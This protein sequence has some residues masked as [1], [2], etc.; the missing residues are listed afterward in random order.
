MPRKHLH[1]CAEF[2]A[3]QNL[4]VR[5]LLGL[6]FKPCWLAF[7]IDAAYTLVV[8]VCDCT[9][10]YMYILSYSIFSLETS[11]LMLSLHVYCTDLKTLLLTLVNF[12]YTV[13]FLSRC[14]IRPWPL[15]CTK[16]QVISLIFSFA[17]FFFF[18]Q[19]NWQYA[20]D[21]VLRSC[22]WNKQILLHWISYWLP[23][24]R[25][26]TGTR[27]LCNKCKICHSV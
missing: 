11:Y 26:W 25:R 24:V 10:L 4:T 14:H 23:C 17:L 15:T 20:R 2:F 3:L 5:N 16:K 9:W 8:I 1:V 13:Y 27:C 6:S 18:P 7:T 21:M 19:D 12:T 22:R